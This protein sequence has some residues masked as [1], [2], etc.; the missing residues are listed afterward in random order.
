MSHATCKAVVLKVWR[1]DD[2]IRETAL[3]DNINISIYLFINKTLLH[4]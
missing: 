2:D 4:N 1:Q 3:S